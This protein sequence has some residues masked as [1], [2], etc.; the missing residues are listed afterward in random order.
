MKKL[1]YRSVFC[2]WYLISLLP[3]GALYALSDSLYYLVD[4]VIRYRRHLVRKHFH[5]CFP[6]KSEAERLRLEKEYYSWFCDYIV[7]TLK[8]FTMSRE[9]M[10]KRM[11]Y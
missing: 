6:E 8:L 9:Q 10:M 11:H 4:Y 2:L 1:I 5:D 7:E 3:W